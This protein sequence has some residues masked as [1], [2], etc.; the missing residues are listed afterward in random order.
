MPPP[1]TTTRACVGSSGGVL[2]PT[3]EEKRRVQQSAA[4]GGATQRRSARQRESIGGAA[5]ARRAV[6]GATDGHEV[7][8]IEGAPIRTSTSETP[9]RTPK[10]SVVPSPLR[11][12]YT[13]ARLR[14]VQA[15]PLLPLVYRL[16]SAQ[17]PT[18]RLGGTHIAALTAVL[19]RRL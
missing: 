13:I 17:D 15:A 11:Y 12:F 18:A 2:P 7:P 14:L 9:F 3:E 4:V 19:L 8:R 6:P 1:H 10:E 16:T 5:T